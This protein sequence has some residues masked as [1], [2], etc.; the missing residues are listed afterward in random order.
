MSQ[1]VAM[2]T[3]YK[4]P[5]PGQ[6]HFSLLGPL[7]QPLSLT[8]QTGDHFSVFDAIQPPG[9]FGALHSHPEVEFMHVLEGTL[10]F[11]VYRDGEAS[12]MDVHPGE[13]VL[14]P[15]NARHA[16][17]NTSAKPVRMLA[18]VG[19]KL[20]RFLMEIARQ[21]NPDALPPLPS[22]E[23]SQSFISTAHRYG[24]WIGSPEENAAIGLT[25]KL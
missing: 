17:R 5:L 18:V 4:T 10:Q 25:L 3:A 8:E 9:V 21:V 15:S 20:G 22:K 2:A 16:I 7:V 11:L 13:S 23:W 12:W 14:V 24:Y 6:P 1:V 19:G